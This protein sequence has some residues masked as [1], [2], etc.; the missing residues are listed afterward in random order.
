MHTQKRCAYLLY[1]PQNNIGRSNERAQYTVEK[2]LPMKQITFCII[3]LVLFFQ[4]ACKRKKEVVVH[5]E[6]SIRIENPVNISVE[7]FIVDIDTIRLETNDRSIMSEI[8]DMYIMDDRF[9]F[10]SNNFTTIFI[11]DKDGKFISKI[12]DRGDGP[13]E[14]IKINSFKVDKIKKRLILADSFTRRIFIYDKEGTQTEVIQL[15]FIPS[16]IVPHTNG[17]LNIYSGTRQRYDDPRMENFNVHFL[18]REGK[19]ISSAIDI[20]TPKK[21]E[22]ASAFMTDFPDNGD[23]LFQPVLSNIIYKIEGKNVVPFYELINS[24]SFR[25]LTQKEKKSFHFYVGMEKNIAKEK[26]E[27]GYLLSWG[28][29]KDLD[30]YVFFSFGGWNKKHYVYHSKRL[31]NTLFIDPDMVKGDK[32]LKEILLNYPK[33][34]KGNRLFVT[35]FPHQIET[36]KNE[37]PKGMLRTFFENTDFE[38]NPLLISFSI[39]FP[40]E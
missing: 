9:Y 4:Y 37:L 32:Y 39:K 2:Y 28:E 26:E 10:L 1:Y 35:P 15:E 19:F 20:E 31:N 23:I 36:G 25:F 29:V 5:A 24:S 7:D 16:V 3:V 38:S 40:E 14:Y 11:Y 6:N 8:L 18:D 33:S 13:E 22:I 34:A 21:I 27:Q 12:N 17:F 30:D